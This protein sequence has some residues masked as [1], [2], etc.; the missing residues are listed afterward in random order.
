[1]QQNPLQKISAQLLTGLVLAIL[2]DSI[3]MGAV[4]KNLYLKTFANIIAQP[5][6]F[7]SQW[8]A[9]IMVWFLLVLGIVLFVLPGTIKKSLGTAALHGTIFGLVLYGVYDFTNYAIFQYWPL[10]VVVIDVAWG[11][12]L[13]CVLTIV[14]S[15]MQAKK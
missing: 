3:W 13:C 7:P 8:L 15:W 9:A 5:L 6:I 1:M 2:I 14:L 4:A 12:F 11:C 10:H